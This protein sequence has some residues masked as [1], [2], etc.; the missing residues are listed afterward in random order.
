MTIPVDKL[1]EAALA[2]FESIFAS[3]ICDFQNRILSLKYFDELDES[4]LSYITD[5]IKDEYE[6]EKT[7]DFIQ[8]NPLFLKQKYQFIDN[9]TKN[10][11]IDSFYK[12][13]PDLRSIG[14]KRINLCLETYI[15]KLNELL[16]N[17]LSPEGK[18]LL[19]EI[20]TSQQRR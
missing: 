6:L 11:F 20:E 12:K 14:S 10:N 7:Q 13:N 16:N 15:D 5:K 2:V 4:I 9:D 19:N 18:I 1:G 17:I 8:Q 3:K